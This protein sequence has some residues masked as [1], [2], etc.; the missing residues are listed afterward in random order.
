MSDD[1]IDEQTTQLSRELAA[2]HE[3]A[4]GEHRWRCS[5]GLRDRVL[6]YATACC[7]DGESQ[8]RVAARLGLVQATLSRWIREA[9]PSDAGF[10]QVAIVPS[11]S[12]QD[13]PHA[14]PLRLVTPRGFIV[15]G[16]DLELLVSLLRIVG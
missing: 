7:D 1:H 9:T 8:C 14:V 13:R 4:G 11:R 2:E 15:E 16:L 5:E 6:A 10:R 3:T 12:G